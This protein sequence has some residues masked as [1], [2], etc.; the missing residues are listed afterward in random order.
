MPKVIPAGSEAAGI[1]TGC[2][3]TGTPGDGEMEGE[4]ST[5]DPLATAW[6]PKTGS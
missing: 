2:P 4:P 3:G 6:A 5:Q 1:H